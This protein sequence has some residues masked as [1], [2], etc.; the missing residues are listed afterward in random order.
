MAP[1]AP[2]GVTPQSVAPWLRLSSPLIEPDL[3]ISRIRLSDWFHVQARV[4]WP[5]W[6]VLGDRTPSSP[7]ILSTEKRLM[8]C[9]D[10]L[11]RRLRKALTRS[12]T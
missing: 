9:V 7:K 10:T 12:R 3:R 4:G 8:P 2:F 11:W 6:S 5:P 1:V